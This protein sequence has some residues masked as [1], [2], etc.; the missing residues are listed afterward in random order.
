MAKKNEKMPKIVRSPIV[1]CGGYFF[2]IAPLMMEVM[3]KEGLIRRKEAGA[4]VYSFV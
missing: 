2:A 3:V 1:E 4:H